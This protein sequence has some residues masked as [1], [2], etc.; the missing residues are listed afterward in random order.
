MKKYFDSIKQKSEIAFILPLLVMMVVFLLIPILKA[1]VMSF[2]YWYMTKPSDRGNYFYG[3][4]NYIEV[5][6]DP[7]FWNS[8]LITFKYIVG[9]VIL[10]YLLGFVSALL[11]NHSFRG[12][13]LVRSLL[14]FP[15]AVPEVVAALIWI[16]MLDKDY[17]I[18]NFILM[19]A[20]LIS[21]NLGYLMD[22]TLALPAAMVVNIWKG[23]PFVAI[24]L[25]AGMQSIPNELYEAS[26]MDGASPWQKMR[27]ITV[28]SIKPI[29]KIIFLLLII[30]TIK[31][32]AIAFCL[33]QG[34]PSRATEL[35]TIYIQQVSFKYFDFGKGAAAGMIMLFFS[36]IFTYYYFKIVDKGE[37]T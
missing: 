30:W 18:I 8:A 9:T 34:G 12:R 10:R 32:Y 17:G 36:A 25:L 29:S 7:F 5:L 31:D 2:Q 4:Q 14:I 28:P 1:V 27:F 3:L 26:D 21:E 13:G 37:E 16:L 24:M 33:A 23:F 19:K 6:K 22:P 15:W 35:L 20:N 11:L